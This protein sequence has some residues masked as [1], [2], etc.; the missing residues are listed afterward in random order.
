[1][2]EFGEKRD[3]DGG[4]SPND[5][6]GGRIIETMVDLARKTYTDELSPRENDGLVRLETTWQ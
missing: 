1:M 3:H 4:G 5:G 6:D 2:T